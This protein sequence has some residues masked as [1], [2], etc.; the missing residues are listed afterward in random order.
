MPSD[1]LHLVLF[2]HLHVLVSQIQNMSQTPSVLGERLSEMHMRNGDIV[3][4][5]EMQAS[6]SSSFEIAGMKFGSQSPTAILECISPP[7]SDTIKSVKTWICAKTESDGVPTQTPVES[8][9]QSKVS[10]RPVA[11]WAFKSLASALLAQRGTMWLPDPKWDGSEPYDPRAL[12]RAAHVVARFVVGSDARVSRLRGVAVQ[13]EKSSN[14]TGGRADFANRMS[15]FRNLVES[16]GEEHGT[17]DQREEAVRLMSFFDE[18][19][20]HL[21]EIERRSFERLPSV[22]HVIIQNPRNCLACT[23]V[24]QPDDCPT[25]FGPRLKDKL[26][27]RRLWR[28]SPFEIREQ[29]PWPP[30]TQLSVGPTVSHTAQRTAQGTVERGP[31][32]RVLRPL[33]PRIDGSSNSRAEASSSGS[34]KNSG[35]VGN[36]LESS[37]PQ[38]PRDE[39]R[40]GTRSPLRRATPRRQSRAA[41]GA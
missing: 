35:E 36:C 38:H 12:E 5:R 3:R 9:P 32:P 16:V 31:R 21:E 19:C 28:F 40:A 30:P 2:C 34:P 41:E 25:R 20:K 37:D 7:N 10:L 27:G 6:S 33:A 24:T 18:Q 39:T 15:T 4:L 29:R 23:L 22:I 11:S 13:V 26:S 17:H 8:D 14:Q 1:D